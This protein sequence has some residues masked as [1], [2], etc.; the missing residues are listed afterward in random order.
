MKAGEKGHYS[1]ILCQTKEA[2]FSK[3]SDFHSALIFIKKA[4]GAERKGK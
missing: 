1:K 4:L 2:M 3:I